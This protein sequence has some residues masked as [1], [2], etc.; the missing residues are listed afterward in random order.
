MSITFVG[1][2]PEILNTPDDKI[3]SYLDAGRDGRQTTSKSGTIPVPVA[4]TKTEFSRFKS[5]PDFEAPTDSGRNN[6]YEVTVQAADAAGNTVSERVRITVENVG[7]DGAI[8]LSHTQPEDR[9]Q[10]DGQ[11]GRCRQG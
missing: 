10:A 1:D 6:V 5:G 4:K 8:T 7:E 3:H 9:G 11:L 2:D